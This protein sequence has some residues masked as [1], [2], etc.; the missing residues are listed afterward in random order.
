MRLPAGA[1]TLTATDAL[2]LAAV[3]HGSRTV[4]GAAADAQ[5]PA[6]TAYGSL[7]RLRDLGL[8]AW[9]DGKAGTLRP[10]VAAVR[11]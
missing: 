3:A 7:T 8:V 11:L 10:L 6:T 2:V 5:V 4:R 1:R 9:E